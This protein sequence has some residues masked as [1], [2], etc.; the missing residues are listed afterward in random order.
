MT[1]TDPRAWL[2]DAFVAHEEVHPGCEGCAHVTMA[3]AL[4]DI[5]DLHKPVERKY[6]PVCDECLHSPQ[7]GAYPYPCPTVLAVTDAL[8]G[9]RG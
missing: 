9:D 8:G 5:L 1:T 4:I 6:G 3:A 7:I 2:Q